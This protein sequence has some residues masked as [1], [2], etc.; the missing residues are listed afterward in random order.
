MKHNILTLLIRLWNSGDI[1]TMIKF[2]IY[3]TISKL[4]NLL[5]DESLNRVE[6][7]TQHLLQQQTIVTCQH[8]APQSERRVGTALN[9]S[10]THFQLSLVWSGFDGWF[11]EIP[12]DALLSAVWERCSII[13]I[14]EYVPT[15]NYGNISV[16][17]SKL[18]I[19]F[20]NLFQLVQVQ[21]AV[22]RSCV[23][24]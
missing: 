1:K 5:N 14:A 19:I 10:H 11:L 13:S 6:R 22:D 16:K 2:T 24:I 12:P 9:F 18:H 20:I 23:L 21:W 8:L 17:A 3:S 7:N 4:L 15:S